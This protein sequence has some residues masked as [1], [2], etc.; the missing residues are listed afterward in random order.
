MRDYSSMDSESQ[1][2]LGRLPRSPNL[3]LLPT[4]CILIS[5]IALPIQRGRTPE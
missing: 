5:A 2:F 4:P 3:G 1:N